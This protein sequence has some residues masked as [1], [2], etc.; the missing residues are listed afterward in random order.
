MDTGISYERY[1]QLCKEIAD[2]DYSYFVLNKSVISDYE[3]DQKIKLLLNIERQHP[4]WKVPWSPSARL[5]D[6]C[7]GAFPTVPHSRPMLSIANAYSFEEVEAFFTRIEKTLG[8]KPTYVLELKID[9]IAVALRYENG[10]FI[11]ALSRGDGSQGEDISTNVRMIRSLPLQLQEECPSFLEVRGEVFFTNHD[12][13]E[14]NRQQQQSGKAAFAN[15]RNAAGGTLKLQSPEEVLK[16]NLSISIY[17]G[18]ANP[19]NTHYD[20]L[21]LFQ[22]WG[23]PVLGAPQRC[24]TKEEVFLALQKIEAE[25][26]SLPMQIDGVVIKI[27]SMD[28]QALLG[29]T[30]KHYRWALAYKYAPERGLTILEDIVVQVGKTGVLTPVAKL[31]PLLLSG[32]TIVRASLYN[33]EEIER[34]DIRIGDSVYVEKGGEIIPKVVGVCKERR[35]EQSKKWS[36]P[37]FCP[38][39][40]SSVIKD[41]GRV[42]SRCV[43]D[44]CSA[45]AIEKICFFVSKSAFDIDHLGPKMVLR[46][47]EAGLVQ[48]CSDIFALK[49]TDLLQLPGF[50]AKSVENILNSIE[51]S[52]KINLDQFLCSLSIPFI[53][54]GGAQILAEHYKNLEEVMAASVQ[55]LVLLDGIG[56]KMANSVVRFFQSHANRQEI[57]AMRDLGVQILD[58]KQE[59]RIYEGQTFVIS[60]SFQKLPR[61]EIEKQIKALGGKVA[62][63]VSKHTNFLILGDSP[64]SKFQKAK[65]LGITIIEEEEFLKKFNSS[66]AV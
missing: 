42:A 23:F 20:N 35:P 51:N 24:Q 34:K 26:D 19:K 30:A 44:H 54:K 53:G 12:F 11:Q 58:Q 39:C 57:N 10:N 52:K 27:D 15:P 36:M 60:G 40:L 4:E 5:G 31:K 37:Q 13:D 18:E 50:Q 28:D 16:R 7:S 48:K 65:E 43:N 62:S 49:K 64:G 22:R 33:E 38:I 17:G 47:F 45:G 3:Y 46:L 63:S 32:S 2:C 41:E 21:L 8:H 59:L 66:D 25:R 6:R 29:M 55:D 9:G 56:E 61:A 1:I 14:L